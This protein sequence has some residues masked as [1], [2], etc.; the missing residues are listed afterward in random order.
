MEGLKPMDI[1]SSEMSIPFDVAAY[2]RGH[3]FSTEAVN[4]SRAIKAKRA[5]WEAVRKA[6]S[7]LEDAESNYSMAVTVVQQKMKTKSA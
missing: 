7:E 1:Y 4:L 2:C 5:A 6:E 3:K